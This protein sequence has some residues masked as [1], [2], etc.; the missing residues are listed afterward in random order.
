MNWIMNKLP[1]CRQGREAKNALFIPASIWVFCTGTKTSPGGVVFLVPYQSK[2]F[3]EA[4]AL[5]KRRK[6]S[7]LE[8][9]PSTP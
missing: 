3:I 7:Q 9:F 4:P 2:L 8:G 1:K 6:I 5:K